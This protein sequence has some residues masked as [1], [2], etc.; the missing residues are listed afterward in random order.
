MAGKLPALYC[1]N[2]HYLNLIEF[3]SH[4]EMR[5]KTK[6]LDLH[7]K[8]KLNCLFDCIFDQ[9]NDAL[10]GRRDLFFRKNGILFIRQ[11]HIEYKHPFA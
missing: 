11:V 6:H 2:I 9:V 4:I 3:N 5:Q 8:N 7:D 10:V 1:P